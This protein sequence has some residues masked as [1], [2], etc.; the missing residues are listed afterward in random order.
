M[1]TKIKKPRR[2][3]FTRALEKRYASKDPWPKDQTILG[4]RRDLVPKK[5]KK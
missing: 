5:E 2:V 3:N 1:R 4:W